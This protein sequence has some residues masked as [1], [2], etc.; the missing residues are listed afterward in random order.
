M[1][2][3]S[4]Y[5]PIPG[6]TKVHYGCKV[7]LLKKVRLI[8]MSLVLF[9]C[10]TANSQE[11]LPDSTLV[12]TVN[13]EAVTFR[14]FMLHARALRSLVIND[15]RIHSGVEYSVDFWS[16]KVDGET[17]LDVLKKRTLDTLVLIKV[18]QIS[19][20]K[21]GIVTD[22]SYGGFL[23]A[24][25]AE[26]ERR[27]IAKSSGKV[28]YG[29]VQYTEE[30][31][32]NYLFS[33]MVNRLK[34]YLANEMFPI[35][36]EMLWETYDKEKD[37]FC[38]KGYYTEISLIKLKH[39][40]GTS[41]DNVEKSAREKESTLVFNDSIYLPEE[42][43]DGLKSIAKEAS[44]KLAKGEYSQVIEFQGA[45]YIILVKEKIPLGSRTFDSCKAAIKI[46]L[47]DRIYDQYI[48][49]L[50]KEATCE[51]NMVVYNKIQS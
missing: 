31:Y 3:F 29:P 37:R 28:I 17:P 21:A 41:N 12:A 49:R 22:I 15:F 25:E 23:K 46:F 9:L 30:V 48:H 50:V 8:I 19:A 20:K 5:I 1:E 26:N 51:P 13:G 24:L 35:T 42:E 6:S 45:F 39:D 40:Q 16:R 44:G 36:N 18:Q 2:L 4:H 32:Y 33:N 10:S 34:E 7:P 43:E 47:L 11:R 27:L 38:R 14:E